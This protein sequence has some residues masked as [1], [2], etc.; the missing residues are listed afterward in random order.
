[1]KVKLCFMIYKRDNSC[2]VAFVSL[3]DDAD[4]KQWEQFRIDHSG[5][6]FPVHEFDLDPMAGFQTVSITQLN[7]DGSRQDE[8]YEKAQYLASIKNSIHRTT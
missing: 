8:D 2:N 6:D 3:G 7:A 4:N 5:Y 1:M